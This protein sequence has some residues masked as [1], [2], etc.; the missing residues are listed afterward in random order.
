VRNGLLIA[1]V[2]LMFA[3]FLP[4]AQGVATKVKL[5]SCV[6]TK[7]ASEPGALNRCRDGR[8]SRYDFF[9]VTDG[10]VYTSAEQ[11]GVLEVWPVTADGKLSSG[12]CYERTRN[13]DGC[14]E[15]LESFSPEVLAASP[16]GRHL[17]VVNRPYGIAIFDIGAAGALTYRNC[18]GVIG[19][20]DSCSEH[21]PGEGGSLYPQQL[22]VSPDGD[23][24][25]A[26]DGR[27]AL[28]F[29]RAETGALEYLGCLKLTKS[30][31]APTQY[32]PF[33]A[34]H[35]GVAVSPDSKFVYVVDP[36]AAEAYK[37][38]GQ[39][40]AVVSVLARTDGAPGLKQV[41]LLKL[42][43]WGVGG[44]G[45]RGRGSA[46]ISPDGRHVYATVK[47]RLVTLTRNK[48]SGTV[49][50]TRC[51]SDDSFPDYDTMKCAGLTGPGLYAA[52]GVALT[53]DGRGLA[54]SGDDGISFFKRNPS[55][56][57]LG[58]TKKGAVTPQACAAKS[59]GGACGTDL[60][61]DF[62]PGPVVFSKRGDRLFTTAWVESVLMS[63]TTPFGGGARVASATGAVD[64]RLGINN[65]MVG[66]TRSKVDKVYRGA[67]LKPLKLAVGLDLISEHGESVATTETVR[68]TLPKGLTWGARPALNRTMRGGVPD[69]WSFTPETQGCTVEG[70]VATCQAVGVRSGTALFGWILD[71]EAAA[72][73]KYTIHGEVVPPTDGRN[74]VPRG[75]QTPASADL[76]LILGERSGAVTVSKVSLYRPPNRPSFVYASADV[77]QGGIAVRA[78]SLSCTTDFPT[79][80]SFGGPK[81]LT[82]GGRLPLPP[83]GV[84]S[85]PHV[86]NNARYTG[87]VM[88]GV[89]EFTVGKTK[90]TKKYSVRIGPG[91]F[92]SGAKGAVI[93]R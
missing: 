87:K 15:V 1:I 40:V 80:R 5:V 43:V 64:H 72:A 82:S 54:L 32:Y 23:R 18:V 42:P 70:Q 9:E 67:E 22:K 19:A 10:A 74:R 27:G 83:L 34:S 79:E 36:Y 25:Y 31:C 89:M 81:V 35:A 11:A 75:A 30:V 61:L 21:V 77:K 49:R 85:C 86:F 6:N 46:A 63:M 17:Y 71:V 50:V 78:D 73:G 56:G 7:Q 90:V 65:W 91:S 2:G 47:H 45:D 53:R 26:F 84:A 28:A 60:P 93:S 88:T 69:Y 76:N 3:G 66:T 29:Q 68:M 38:K 12:P 48:Q 57:A 62:G 20:S 58:T 4:A 51:M 39:A 14:G 33:T 44:T 8:V 37:V 59:K 41:Q 92:L 52:H 13:R 16:D 24:L 55:T